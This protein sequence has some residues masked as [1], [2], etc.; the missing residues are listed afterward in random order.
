[1]SARGPRSAEELLAEAREH[2]LR[3]TPDEAAEAVE[4]GAVLVDTRDSGDQRDEGFIPGA[5]TIRRTVLEWRA[6]P[7]SDWRDDRIAD[8]SL[9]LIVVCNDGYSSSLAAANLR[10]LGFEH[11]GDLDGG[12][13]AWKKAGLPTS[14]A[15]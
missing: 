14:P 15:D 3:Y 5:V 11:A 2:I 6:D 12:F 7:Q 13:R 1:M 9:R 8:R 10:A 4:A